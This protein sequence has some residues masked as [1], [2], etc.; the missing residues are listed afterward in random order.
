MNE[1]II[2]CT[3]NPNLAKLYLCFAALKNQ[4]RIEEYEVLIVDNG[5]T[6]QQK[7]Q[8]AKISEIFEFLYIYLPEANLTNARIEGIKYNN[9]VER[10][11]NYLFID[12][13]NYIHDRYLVEGFE[14][15]RANPS[16]GVLAGKSHKISSLNNSKKIWAEKYMAIRDLGDEIIVQGDFEWNIADPHGAGMFINSKVASI[17]LKFSEE[18]RETKR[19]GRSGKI[20]NS[21]EDTLICL[22][23]KRNGLSTAY[24][25][26][27]ALT[28]DVDRERFSNG[29]LLRLAIGMGRSDFHLNKL[30][31]LPEPNWIPRTRKTYLKQFYAQLRSSGFGESVFNSLRTWGRINESKQ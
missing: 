13:D 15:L 23:A 5:T 24:L 6:D 29:Y 8:V 22:L 30:V 18:Q 3:H 31:G 2:V 27:L 16:T 25:P 19:L 11:T 1:R 20:L 26:N 9:G 4:E 14:Y 21:G 7:K 10:D 28:H 12:D 17:F